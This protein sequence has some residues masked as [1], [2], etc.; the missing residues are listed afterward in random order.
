MGEPAIAGLVSRHDVWIEE[1]D[2]P[3]PAGLAVGNGIF[4]A[5][6]Y[7]P[8]ERFEWAVNHLEVS[9]GL[10]SVRE[11]PTGH[12]QSAAMPVDPQGRPITHARVLPMMDEGRWEE[13]DALY[14]NPFIVRR[15]PE[16]PGIEASGY[17]LYPVAAWLRLWPRISKREVLRAHMSGG[18]AF[19]QRLDLLESRVVTR[20]PTPQ[21][22]AEIR[23]F[24]TPDRP[25][26]VIVIEGPGTESAVA[27]LGLH[28][29]GI[30]PHTE[31]NDAAARVTD[32][33]TAEM[34]LRHAYP[35]VGFHYAVA[36]RVS[37]GLWRVEPSAGEPTLR[38]ER[39]TVPRLV[40][41]LA[42][43]TCLDDHD[44]L[45][46]A[47]GLV[48]GCGREAV[49][50]FE[51]ANRRHWLDF[52]SR[53]GIESGDDFLDSLWYVNLHA[54]AVSCARGHRFRRQACGL[55]GILPATDRT[56]WGN[57]W[58][59]DVNIQEAYS[60]AN[61]SNHLELAAAFHDGVEA[62]APVARQ[63]ARDFFGLEGLCYA[64]PW[65]YAS[66]YHC[67]GPWYALYLW[68]QS[69]CRSDQLQFRLVRAKISGCALNLIPALA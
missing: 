6:S 67:S 50:S 4:G 51:A 29:P 60:P 57:A 69:G 16:R 39:I 17:P 20:I 55:S 35:A 42:I 61:A 47:R 68:W 63:L 41:A 44:P 12:D 30:E 43:S 26:L 58:V 59:L 31:V 23:T 45:R 46:L 5:V 37:G 49:E 3:W 28:R 15:D 53:S 22:T 32:N 9:Q 24:V 62:L 8:S 10:A 56:K 21:G 11:N 66:Y 19:L 33:G 25:V 1:P 48:E 2:S 34:Y 13:L 36:A 64:W 54:L 7:Q 40:I 27:R 14:G 65:Y 18:D 52:W 38:L